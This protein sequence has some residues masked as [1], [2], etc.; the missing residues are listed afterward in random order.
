MKPIDYRRE[1]I[2]KKIQRGCSAIQS[3]TKTTRMAR[4]RI[5]K[6]LSISDLYKQIEAFADQHGLEKKKGLERT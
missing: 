4:T 6:T 5:K 2:D 1:N 3:P